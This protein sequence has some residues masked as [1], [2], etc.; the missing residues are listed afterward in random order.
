[1]HLG[2]HKAPGAGTN[3]FFS[4]NRR[5]DCVISMNKYVQFNSPHGQ[6][7]ELNYVC[8]DGTYR[9]WIKSLFGCAMCCV[10]S[11][12]QLNA[13]F[14]HRFDWV[15]LNWQWLNK[16]QNTFVIRRWSTPMPN[17][18]RLYML[19]CWNVEK[20]PTQKQL[21]PSSPKFTQDLRSA[22]Q[23]NKTCVV[24]YSYYR[25]PTGTRRIRRAV[26]TKF[27]IPCLFVKAHGCVRHNRILFAFFISL[28]KA[29]K[30][31]GEQE[32][33]VKQ[34]K[35]FAKRENVYNIVFI[36]CLV[37]FRF[38]RR[39]FARREYGKC[40]VRSPDHGKKCG[41]GKDNAAPAVMAAKRNFVFI[42]KYHYV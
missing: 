38:R 14:D 33:E 10:A 40:V 27:F 28:H 30:Q 15:W 24:L 7:Y 34:R 2:S 16:Y 19:N 32:E 41:E 1:M 23:I 9:W 22:I 4:L 29:C 36:Y 12:D 13:D 39:Q 26:L 25:Q 18:S 11:R 42:L 37:S 6:D 20:K 8:A 31:L 5:K 17:T 35:N 21:S 3:H